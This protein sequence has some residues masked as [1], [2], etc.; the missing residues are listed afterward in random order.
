MG[1]LSG[2][3]EWKIKITLIYKEKKKS[4]GEFFYDRSWE[5]KWLFKSTSDSLELNA[6]I[7]AWRG[8]PTNWEKCIEEKEN[9]EHI[10]ME[11]E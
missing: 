11:C 5:S 7:G 8:I 2:E 4:E 9:L 10:I 3:W 6:R 1:A